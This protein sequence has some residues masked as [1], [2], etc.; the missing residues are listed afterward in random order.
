MKK[1]ILLIFIAV[2]MGSCHSADPQ[3]NEGL[4]DTDQGTEIERNPTEVVAQGQEVLQQIAGDYFELYEDGA[5]RY[6]PEPCGTSMW[7]VQIREIYEETGFWEISWAGESY[8]IS[9]AEFDEN[10]NINIETTSEVEERFTFLTNPNSKVWNFD[11][12]RRQTPDIVRVEDIEE[13]DLRP[14]T[15]KEKIMEQM[16]GSWYKLELSDGAEVIHVPCGSASDG[17]DIADDGS[18]IDFRS[19]SDP[20]EIISISKLN[21]RI[22]IIHRSAFG[23]ESDTLVIHDKYGGVARVGTGL[24]T[25]PRY[26]N[27]QSRSSYQTVEEECY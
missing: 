9:L 8:P 17:F 26:V 4:V 2:A 22:T 19:G 18:S 16:P 24:D 7:D 6:Y 27:E 20:N 13:F 14:C 1:P 5:D 11:S 12:G 3:S 23:G 25:D 15:D 21:S 10:G